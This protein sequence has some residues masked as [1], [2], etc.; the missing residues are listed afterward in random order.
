MLSVGGTSWNGIRISSKNDFAIVGLNDVCGFQLISGTAYSSSTSNQMDVT[1]FNQAIVI[2]ACARVQIRGVLFDGNS[3]ET[4]LLGL[5]HVSYS[6]ITDCVFRNAADFYGCGLT[7]HAGTN[8]VYRGNQFYS[9]GSGAQIGGASDGDGL[10]LVEQNAAFTSNVITNCLASTGGAGL[11]MFAQYSLF[12]ANVIV[13]NN[14][15]ICIASTSNGDAIDVNFLSS[16]IAITG[17]VIRGSVGCGIKTDYLVSNGAAA[18]NATDIIIANNIIDGNGTNISSGGSIVLGYVAKLA[19]TNN[20]IKN[21]GS[22]NGTG[23]GVGVTYSQDVTIS[24]N[25]ISTIVPLR[26]RFHTSISTATTTPRS[27]RTTSSDAPRHLIRV[28]MPSC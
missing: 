2:S 28:G 12:A 1:G 18:V 15:G 17:N 14:Q 3:V 20:V 6:L 13:G 22:S 21:Y 5:S 19:I 23:V 25:Q 26:I 9:C 16:H 24:G 8:N 27:S 4:G 11:W 10:S 7:S